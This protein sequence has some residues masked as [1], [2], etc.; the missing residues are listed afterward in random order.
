M[1]A[2]EY[3]RLEK[4]MLDEKPYR[5]STN[6]FPIGMRRHNTKCF[7]VR[8]EDGQKVFDVAYSYRYTTQEVTKEEY[9]AN[10]D[11]KHYYKR[12][13][14][15]D[16][17][18]VEGECDYRRY[19]NVPN[20][21]GVVRPDNTFEFTAERYGQGELGILSQW[22]MGWFSNDSRRGGMVYKRAKVVHPIYRGMKVYCDTM[23]PVVPYTVVG[24]R[25][26][27]KMS[28]ELM[29]SY[30]D[31]YKVSEVMLKSMDYKTFMDTAA[32]IYKEHNQDDTHSVHDE[33]Y[34][35]MLA[36][37]LKD[38]APLDA[39][40]MYMLGHDTCRF[41][42]NLHYALKNESRY[43]WN[44]DSPEQMFV[45]LKRRMNKEVY[46]R[47]E[48]IFKDHVHEYG[49]QYPASEWGVKIIV[50]GKEVQQLGYGV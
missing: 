29:S 46:K 16:G 45:V 23:E 7:Y 3:S 37:S 31:F 17:K 40:V 13:V 5:G 39:T 35:L 33:K 6:R 8:E 42:W 26:Q 48:N 20:I 41:Q 19:E 18:V 47:N 25:V 34:W 32:E 30:K 14:W 11:D 15:V 27:R 4:I 9:E 36:D 21:L 2:L 44:E 1:K 22:S 50:D 10:A 12:D 49:K 28:G 38:K 24:K 43:S